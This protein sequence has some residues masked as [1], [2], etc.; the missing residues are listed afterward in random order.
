LRLAGTLYPFRGVQ[1]LAGVSEGA[2]WWRSAAVIAVSSQQVVVEVAALQAAGFADAD[3]PSTVL[4][5]N[6]GSTDPV[7]MPE[8]LPK[9]GQASFSY[10]NAMRLSGVKDAAGSH[11]T[12]G[13]DALGRMSQ[14]TQPFDAQSTDPDAQSITRKMGYD[15]NGNPVLSRT[16]VAA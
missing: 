2:G 7:P 6:F 3:H 13:Y 14:M 8:V 11:S 10:D 15:Y 16:H 1:G 4:Q 12:M 9:A 5:G